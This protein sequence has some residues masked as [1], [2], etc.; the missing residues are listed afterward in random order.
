[1]DIKRTDGAAEILGSREF[2]FHTPI[3]VFVFRFNSKLQKEIVKVNLK[4]F[5]DL[6]MIRIKSK[7][8]RTGK[9]NKKEGLLLEIGDS[10]NDQFLMAICKIAGLGNIVE[11]KK[12][13]VD[14]AELKINK[15]VLEL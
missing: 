6:Y 5:S 1:M 13:G 12:R 3:P 15:E 9:L 4:T 10:L 14:S 8:F 2:V 7:M 11:R